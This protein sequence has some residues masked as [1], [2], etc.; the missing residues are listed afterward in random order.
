MLAVDNS[1][2]AIRVCRKRGVRDARVASVTQISS[3]LGIFDT[4]L[5]LGNNFG[6]MGNPKRARWLLRRFDRMTPNDG[7]VIA[8]SGDPNWNTEPT[9]RARAAR[10]AKKGRLPGEFRLRPQYR[11]YISLPT[12]WLYASK[13]D[14]V[15]ILEDTAWRVTEFFDDSQPSGAFVAL[16]EKKNCRTKGSSRRP[17]GRR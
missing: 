7:I 2:L 3:R 13:D 11:R 6:L 12:L 9:F 8:G 14:M 16:I 17:K 4:I 15:A 10:N 1:P 5:M